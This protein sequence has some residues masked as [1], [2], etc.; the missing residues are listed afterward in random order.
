MT[1]VE[2]DLGAH[3]EAI[4]NGVFEIESP[5]G[6]VHLCWAALHKLADQLDDGWLQTAMFAVLEDLDMANVSTN[7]IFTELH[8]NVVA[9]TTSAS[10]PDSATKRA[11]S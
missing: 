11:Q 9:V 3:L 10:T 4:R 6:E 2:S 1:A 7:R 8:K 5:I